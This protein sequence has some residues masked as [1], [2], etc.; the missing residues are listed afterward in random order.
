VNY[1]FLT[2][3]ERD[4]ETGLDYFG[5]RYYGST[6]GRFTSIDPLMESAEP[7]M[8]QSWNRYS[9]VLNNPLG[10]TDPTGEIWVRS[11]SGQI[12][13]FSQE[14]WDEEI[15]MLKDSDGN[16]VYTPLTPSEMEFNTNYGRV[17]LNPNGPDADAAEGSD[18]YYGFSIVGEN[19]TDYSVALAA[20]I[21]VGVRGRHPILMLG[22]ATIAT[23]WVLSSP[24]QQGLPVVDPN[25]YS[26]SKDNKKKADGLIAAAAT[27]LGK[28]RSDPPGPGGPGDHHKKEIKAMLDRAKRIVQ[29]LTGNSKAER[30]KQIQEIEKAA[31]QH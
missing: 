15:S 10:Y 14:R 6:Q 12:V 17:R 7:T 13:W 27:E 31:S 29:R 19:K 22:G 28:L 25:F 8:P 23:L 20:G 9:Y 11:G 5:A 26:Q 30:L 4:V 21:A 1:S 2:L 3:K 24:V 18:A 16:A